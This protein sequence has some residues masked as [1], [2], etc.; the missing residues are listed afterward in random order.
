[1]LK[2]RSV[3]YYELVQVNLIKLSVER[4]FKM[5]WAISVSVLEL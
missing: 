4:D 3:E 5:P 1:M 2:K